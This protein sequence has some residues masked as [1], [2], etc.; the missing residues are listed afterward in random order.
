MDD[1]ISLINL[2]YNW[3]WVKKQSTQNKPMETM[4]ELF[5]IRYIVPIYL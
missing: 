4:G 5:S 3:L 1:L 2:I